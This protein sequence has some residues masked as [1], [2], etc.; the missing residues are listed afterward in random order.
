MDHEFRDSRNAPDH[1]RLAVDHGRR[2]GGPELEGTAGTGEELVVE[3]EGI[4]A[5]F[6]RDARGALK[7]CME[8]EGYSKAELRRIGEELIGRVT[9]QYVYHKLVTELA[10]RN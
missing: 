6:S 9:Q 8:G 1:R 2:H 10:E 4:R 3:K 5:V 7:V